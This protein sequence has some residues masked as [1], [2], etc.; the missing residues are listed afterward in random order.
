MFE[1]ASDRRIKFRLEALADQQ[2]VSPS[3]SRPQRS[4]TGFIQG[5]MLIL[6]ASPTGRALLQD[7]IR[8]KTSVGIDPLLEPS[9]SFFYPAQ[10]HF[11][12]GYQPEALQNTEKGVGRY[13]ASFVNGLRR[14]WHASRGC[15]ADIS[16]SPEEY[17]LMSRCEEADV[18][19]VLHLIGWELRAAGQASLWRY[20]LSG[21]DGDLAVIFERSVAESAQAQFDG[22]ALRATFDQWFAV[23]ARADSS[24][25]RALDLIDI[26]MLEKETALR[27]GTNMMVPSDIRKTGLLPHGGNYL[28]DGI[29]TGR[30]YNGLMEERNRAHLRSLELELAQQFATPD[31]EKIIR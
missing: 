11:D 3:I 4:F 19:A 8:N 24:D 17:L 5:L 30:W 12:F 1:G 2:P 23:H 26:A 22:Q 14:A 9:G 6:D 20:L 7:A 10:N 16:F 13:L 27:I 31:R 25:R 28:S 29:F 21:P 18:E 15:R